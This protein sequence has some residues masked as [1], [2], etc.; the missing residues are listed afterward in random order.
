MRKHV[1]K[2]DDVLNEQ[3]KVIY[4]QR[5]EILHGEDLT[6]TIDAFREDLLEDMLRAAMP[7][8][9]LPE[10]WQLETLK[11]DLAKVFNVDADVV[12]WMKEA[13]D[14]DNI[15]QK[16]KELTEKAWSHT[17]SNFDAPQ[18]QAIFRMVLLQALDNHWR[19][20]LQSLDYLRKGINWRGYAQKDPINEFAKES[21]LLFEDLLANIKLETVSMLSRV[22]K[23]KEEQIVD[24][25]AEN[26]APPPQVKAAP[27]TAP[28]MPTP[29]MF[30]LKSWDELNPLDDRIPRNA[31]CPCGSGVRF[32]LCHGRLAAAP[33]GEEIS[34]GSPKK[35]VKDKAEKTVKKAS[36]KAKKSPAKKLAKTKKS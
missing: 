11:E 24:P 12:A 23:V 22:Q 21:Y 8:G 3:R 17:L 10:Q 36:A 31:P 27:Q 15:Q 16:A 13:D 20:H 26:A 6:E 18:K 5:H 19:Q 4:D 25:A 29:S 28:S 35:S 9:S 32:K 7:A 34:S 33:Q 30:G 1:L 2:F 14:A